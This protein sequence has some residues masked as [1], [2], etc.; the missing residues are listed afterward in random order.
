MWRIRGYIA[1]AFWK[2]K[3]CI[4]FLDGNL[5]KCSRQLQQALMQTSFRFHNDNIF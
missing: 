5:L 2:R 1:K 3:F 4:Q